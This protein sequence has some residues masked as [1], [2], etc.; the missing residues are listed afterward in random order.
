MKRRQTIRATPVRPRRSLTLLWF[1]AGI[2]VVKLIVVLQLKDH[3]L[4]Q[5]S[6]T[7][8]TGAYVDL[9]RRVIG[10]DWGLG[11]GLYY[12][13]PLYIYFLAMLYGTTDS[14]TA[15]RVVQI[16]LGTASVGMLFAT[17]RVWFGARAAWIAAV[18]AALTGLFTFY[19][20][21]L[22]Q[23]SLDI[24]LTSAALW[25]LA[26]SLTREGARWPILT[27]IAFGLLTLNRPNAIIAAG[28]V[29][30][31]LLIARRWRPSVLLAAGLVAALVPVGVRNIRVAGEWSLVSS[32][33]GLNF[34]IG[35]GEGAT[36]FFRSIPGVMPTIEGQARDT[37]T[38]AEAALGRRL[39]DAEVSGYF[40]DRAWQ[41]I[42][43]HPV[44]WLQLL[45]RKA[46]YTLNAQHSAL[47]LSYPF[48][49]YDAGTALRVLFVGPWLLIPLGLFGL[50]LA[51][52]ADRRGSYLI[53]ASFVPVYAASV[54][55]F[56]VSER[57]RLPLLVPL[58]IG[59]GAGLDL[60]WR[61][62]EAR[63]LRVLAISAAGLVALGL[64]SNWPLNFRDADG[65]A[66]ER[67]RMAE[68]EAIRGNAPE[69]RRWL[70]L[71]LTTYP[72]PS[73]AHY[74]M[75]TAF[76]NTR[77]WADAIEQLE[78]ARKLDPK[79]AP[80]LLA[81]G[82]TQLGAERFADA[83]PVLQQALALAPA[84]ADT[85]ASLA[86]A[87]LELGMI[88]QAREHVFAALRVDP[89]HPLATDLR[90]AVIR[91]P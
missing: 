38:V 71:A 91:G 90:P 29:I 35:N 5:P 76:A 82:R 11:P 33:G 41:W 56:F 3:I 53:W 6:T 24:A 17:A 84:S 48:Y 32:H 67:V 52:P 50:A 14:L 64:A 10:G 21:V 59:A 39:T 23:A 87:E 12:V 27:G 42:R 55:L 43:Q 47:P 4:L 70:A 68:N 26:L 73:I 80:V 36:G 25:L 22:L 74:R 28:S 65:R 31:L 16:A 54:A 62:V 66:E 49:A 88:A 19:E 37:R 69:A 79:A 83:L 7:M 51:A 44:A 20:A 78:A 15:V 1:L 2:F 9:A 81:L 72:M 75:G 61:H 46:F 85:L 8:D 40:S 13:S 89:A 77:Q 30:G 18:A 57:Y 58:A 86:F 34:L 63:H 45:V 60:L